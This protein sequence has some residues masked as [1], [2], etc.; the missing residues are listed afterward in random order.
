MKA[1]LDRLYCL[2]EFDNN[3]RPRAWSSRLA[4]QNRKVVIATVC[5]Q[6]NIKDMGFAIEAM[7]QPM[8]A[9]GFDVIGTLPVFKSFEKGAVKKQKEAMERAFQL[10]TELGLQ[11]TSPV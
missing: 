1:F 5:E 2:Y 3:T 6:E 7:Q 8:E 10:G 9:L 4:D 11:L